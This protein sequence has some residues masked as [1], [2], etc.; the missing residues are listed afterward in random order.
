MAT[1]HLV[2]WVKPPRRAPGRDYLVEITGSCST[3][4][5]PLCQTPYP[6]RGT[7]RTRLRTRGHERAHSVTPTR[8]ILDQLRTFAVRLHEVGDPV[9][10]PTTD[11]ALQRPLD[12][13]RTRAVSTDPEHALPFDALTS[14]TDCGEHFRSALVMTAP[15]GDDLRRAR[16]NVIGTLDTPAVTSGATSDEAGVLGRTAGILGLTDGNEIAT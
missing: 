2:I 6:M 16:P 8:R 7:D 14:A 3:G 5:W 4:Y 15:D 1:A 12:Q 11:Q 10:S 13:G 9:I